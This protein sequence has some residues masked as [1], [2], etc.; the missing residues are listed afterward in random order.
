[1]LSALKLFA[2]MFIFGEQIDDAT[3][4]MRINAMNMSQFLFMRLQP[5]L[6]SAEMEKSLFIFVLCLV[7]DDISAAELI[8][9]YW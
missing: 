7:T 4:W 2:S 1:M 3:L 6:I 8:I 9:W 5:S